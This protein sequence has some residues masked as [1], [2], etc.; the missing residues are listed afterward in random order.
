MNFGL[1]S[2]AQHAKLTITV[3]AADNSPSY[4]PGFALYQG[5]MAW[6]SKAVRHDT[7][8]FGDN[9]PGRIDSE[10]SAGGWHHQHPNP[11]AHK[12]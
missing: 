7:I 11:L 8:Y 9:G 10:K 12:A 2:L 4:I 3:A 6:G 5:W 1:I